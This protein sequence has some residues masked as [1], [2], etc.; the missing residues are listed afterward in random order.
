MF[1][2]LNIFLLSSLLFVQVFIFLFSFFF[3]FFFLLPVFWRIQGHVCWMNQLWSRK[4]YHTR[5]LTKHY[6]Q[7]PT[8]HD[9]VLSQEQDIRGPPSFWRYQATVE[10]TGGHRVP[11][12]STIKREYWSSE[13][14]WNRS[15]DVHIPKMAP[16]NPPVPSTCVILLR[17]PFHQ[18]NGGFE[19][20]LGFPNV[21]GFFLS[22][23]G[24][25]NVPVPAT[26]YK[27]CR[28]C[29]DGF[30]TQALRGRN[31][32]PQLLL[33]CRSGRLLNKIVCIPPSIDLLFLS[34]LFVSCNFPTSWQRLNV[35]RA[36]P[37]G[38]WCTVVWR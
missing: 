33:W 18:M 31:P 20:S 32:I 13:Q 26:T 9:L 11:V 16:L 8:A 10:R 6:N 21:A 4:K 38:L 3:L 35:G 1:K 14:C 36:D 2:N 15:E 30:Q 19:T 27:C 29:W 28:G 17:G 5:T 34:F 23:S 22:K 37:I 7:H 12:Q 24:I 25:H